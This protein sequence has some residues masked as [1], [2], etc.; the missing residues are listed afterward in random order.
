MAD[1]LSLDD[2]AEHPGCK[3]V[4]EP[5]AKTAVRDWFT[6]AR[7]NSLRTALETAVPTVTWTNER[8]VRAVRA[9]AE[10]LL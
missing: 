10:D 4:L 8:I 2:L 1:R 3:H 7:I 9:T 6:P 5:L